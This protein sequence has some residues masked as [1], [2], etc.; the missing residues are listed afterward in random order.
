MRLTAVDGAGPPEA[1]EV[2]LKNRGRRDPIGWESLLKT[3][4]CPVSFGTDDGP[5]KVRWDRFFKIV[6]AE[7]CLQ[8]GEGTVLIHR[9]NGVS[10]HRNTSQDAHA[11]SGYLS[12]ADHPRLDVKY[13]RVTIRPEVW[14]RVTV[15]F[16]G[17]HDLNSPMIRLSEVPR[18]IAARWRPK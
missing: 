12:Y 4:V 13:A 10:V 14:P 15:C 3:Q 6:A 9:R 16:F 18:A 5:E 17:G 2:L 1:L 8:I 7:C 11:L